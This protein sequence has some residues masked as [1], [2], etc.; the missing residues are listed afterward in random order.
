MPDATILLEVEKRGLRL[1]RHIE[2][3]PRLARARQAK[4][5]VDSIRCGDSDLAIW[6]LKRGFNPNARDIK[7]RGALWWAAACCRASV[8]RELV[9]RGAR[10]PDNV[11]MG[12]V[13]AGDRGTVRFLVERGANVNCMASEYSPVGRLNIREVL[14]TAA[15]GAAA[16]KPE[17]ESIPI[18]LIRAGARVNRLILPQ[19]VPGAGNRS[20]LGLA[21]YYGFIK[22]IKAMIVAGAEVN[23][24]DGDGRTALFDA[25][26][27]GHSSV[28][29]VLLRAGARTD[30][31]DHAGMTPLEAVRQKHR[32]REMIHT[33]LLI[34]AGVD[35]DRKRQ[36]AQAAAWGKKRARIIAFLER[37]SKK[38]K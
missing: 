15:M 36:T 2:K 38:G 37:R 8:I 31:K 5:L 32:S 34:S 19:P 30:L 1:L 35:V 6:F 21:A 4:A 26:L 11:L 22:T 10:L 23:L 12:P 17:L 13:Q 25:L 9:R 27:Q 16:L 29:K 3:V 7:G 18:M 33:E 14:L 24:R 20:M 28:A